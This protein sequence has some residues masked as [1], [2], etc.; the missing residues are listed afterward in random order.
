M[1]QENTLPDGSV[2]DIQSLLHSSEIKLTSKE[3]RFIFW[4]TYPDSDSFLHKKR[5]ALKAG[6]K[7]SNAGACGIRLAK[8]L[9]KVI[10]FVL[11]TQVKA[12]L[13]KEYHQI[14]A[15]KRQRVHFDIADYYHD[16]GSL[17][18]LTELTPAQRSVIDGIDYKGQQGIMVYQLANREREMRDLLDM[19]NKITGITDE[20]SNGYDIEA[21]ADI[22]KGELSLKVSKRQEK[23]Q[24][25]RGVLPE[26]LNDENEVEEL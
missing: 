4:Y 8:K 24:Q 11:D 16:D 5:A 18:E 17:K 14:L 2:I 25:W 9:C 22:I 7:E 20:T 13:Q 1:K 21:T 19:Y 3:A 12:D 15:L 6:Y 10:N 26:T 23:Q